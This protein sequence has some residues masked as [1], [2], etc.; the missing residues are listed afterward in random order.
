MSQVSVEG[1]VSLSL[2]PASS[3]PDFGPHHDPAPWSSPLSVPHHCAVCVWGAPSSG[4]QLLLL[5]HPEVFPHLA[6]SLFLT[7]VF[8]QMSPSP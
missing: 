1:L 7:P 3:S 2:T 6:L 5:C 8:V 4:C